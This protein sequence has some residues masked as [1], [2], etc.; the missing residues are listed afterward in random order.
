MRTIWVGMHASPTGTRLLVMDGPTETV[1]KA[2]LGVP[3]H[4]RAVAALLEA[5]ALWQG[6]PVR[7]AL[8]ADGSADSSVTNRF[9][10]CF[11]D[12]G[13]PLYTLEHVPAHPVRRRR[14]VLGGLGDF[15]DLRQ[16]LLLFE[17]GR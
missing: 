1:L 2:R 8:V 3:Q 9:P 10:D 11:D 17:V 12:N 13:A 15:R 16:Q 5:L 7:A 6:A 14:D 4:R